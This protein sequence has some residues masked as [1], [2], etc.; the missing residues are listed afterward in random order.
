M[1]ISCNKMSFTTDST[2][3]MFLLDCMLFEYTLCRWLWKQLI[4]QMGQER[5]DT[6][7]SLKEELFL[8]RCASICCIFVF[9]LLRQENA[10]RIHD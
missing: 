1:K 5:L 4:L 6:F 8:N 10:R 9:F 3:Q 2:Y 7:K